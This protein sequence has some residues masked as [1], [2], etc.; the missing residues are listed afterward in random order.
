MHSDAFAELVYFL[1]AK[2]SFSDVLLH[3]L[4]LSCVTRKLEKSHIA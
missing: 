2:A 3:G 4:T 1:F